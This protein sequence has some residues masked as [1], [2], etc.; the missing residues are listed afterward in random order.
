VI[1]LRRRLAYYVAVVRW[2]RDYLKWF[3]ASA[4]PPVHPLHGRPY[5]MDQETRK[6]LLDRY[7]AREPK[8]PVPPQG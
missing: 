6:L 2:W 8:R 7:W 1:G 5:R 4:F 3:T